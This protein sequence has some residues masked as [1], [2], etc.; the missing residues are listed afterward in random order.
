MPSFSGEV[1]NELARLPLSKSCCELAEL[2]GLLR[3][4]ASLTLG[5]GRA[6]GLAFTTEHAAVARRV[7]VLLKQAGAVRTEVMVRR[8]KRL[9]KTN[10]YAVRVMPGETVGA[11]LSEL[12]LSPEAISS[13]GKAALLRRKCCRVSYLRGAFL[14]GGSVSRPEASC[15]LEYVTTNYQFAEL[16]QTLLRRLGFSAGLTGRKEDYVV[17][18]KEGDAIL[19]FLAMAGAEEAATAFEAVRN[20][21][22]VRNQVN[23]LVNCETANLGKTAAAAA[24]Q[25]AAI[26]SFAAAGGLARLAPGLR[27][28]AEARLAHPEASLAELGA[29]LG[30]G[31]SGANHRLRRLMEL[32]EEDLVR[33]TGG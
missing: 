18:L 6:L 16:L 33:R 29:E 25:V 28:A 23:R 24:R 21:K 2:A 32:A 20:V 13:G 10:T 5:A 27:A 3:M 14:A 22:E 19:D 4:G 8:S 15:H 1:K 30:V 26:R 7:L 11:L 31:R 9:G 17:Y 12:G